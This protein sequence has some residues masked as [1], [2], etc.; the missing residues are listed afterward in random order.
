MSQHR[1]YPWIRERLVGDT[2]VVEV[3]GEMDALSA[4]RL[5]A[6]LDSLTGGDRPDVVLDL[7]R[8]TFLDCSG[9]S[10]LVR[11]QN[12]ARERYGRVRLV[13]DDPRTLRT[14]RITQ[15]AAHFTIMED[16]AEVR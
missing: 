12:R 8:V 13:C 2:V 7:R 5:I 9:L 15:L 1:L 14:L 6:Y 16:L 10:A 4:P 11:T 3:E